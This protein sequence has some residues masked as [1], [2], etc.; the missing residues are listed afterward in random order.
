MDL[1]ESKKRLEE[2]EK[3]R[4]ELLKLAREMRI[5]ATKAIAAI[6]SGKGGEDEL[7]QAISIMEKLVEY[8]QKCPEIYF[9]LTHDAMQELVEAVCFAKAVSQNFD[10]R[11]ELP[12]EASAYVT[13]LADVIGELRRYTLSKL[14]IGEFKEAERLMK[15]MEEIYSALIPFTALP[16]KLVPGLRHKLDVARAAIERTKSDYIAA[17]VAMHEDLGRD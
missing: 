15:L 2:L 6:H 7:Q 14:V 3:S 13:G 16:D 9:S 10:F 5:R 8:K 1:E 12:V 11:V 4:E 17:R